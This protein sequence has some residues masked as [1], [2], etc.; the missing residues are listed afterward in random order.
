MELVKTPVVFSLKEEKPLLCNDECSNPISTKD[1]VR[2]FGLVL[3]APGHSR[4]PN[5]NLGMS[6]VEGHLHLLHI[7]KAIQ[8]FEFASFKWLKVPVF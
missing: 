6:Q 2:P 1:P 5:T 3:K 7:V 8:N 4:D